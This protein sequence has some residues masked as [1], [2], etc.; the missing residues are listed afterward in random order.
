MRKMLKKPV[1]FMLALMMVLGLS[2]APVSAASAPKIENIDYEG[3][4]KVE[5][6]F[7]GHVAY[8]NCYVSVKDTKGNSYS[9]K[10]LEKDSDDLTFKIKKY[11]TNRTYNF[12]IHGIKKR[13]TTGWKNVS[14]KVR[15]PGSNKVVIKDIEYDREDREVEFE[16]KGKVAWKSPTVKIT[17]S[18]GKNYVR[19]IIDKDNNSIEVKVNKLVYGKSYNY[20]ITGVKN[21]EGTKYVTKT[22]K[23]KAVESRY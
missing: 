21:K 20:K 12:T 18:N 17:D 11:K 16:F 19:Y 13:G 3:Y 4:G 23:F 14:G 5:V 1:A 10:I 6:E 7:Y 2:L 15:I 8:K 22:G 9:T